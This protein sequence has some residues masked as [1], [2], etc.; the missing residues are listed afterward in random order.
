MIRQA[1]IAPER[2]L[3]RLDAA[4][5]FPRGWTSSAGQ[6]GDLMPRVLSLESVTARVATGDEHWASTF[7]AAGTDAYQVV[8]LVFVQAEAT[9]L[10]A[11][12]DLNGRI[13]RLS[14]LLRT[15]LGNQSIDVQHEVVLVD[16]RD[17]RPQVSDAVL[18]RRV[19]QAQREAMPDWS[20]HY[21]AT[22]LQPQ[23]HVVMESATAWPLA[24][25][26]LLL[27]LRLLG[28]RKNDGPARKA[29]AWRGFA[30]R[31]WPAEEEARLQADLAKEAQEVLESGSAA[32]G[33][34]SSSL[35]DDLARE[36]RRP[37]SALSAHPEV[38]PDHTFAPKELKNQDGQAERREHFRTGP[39][40]A[41]FHA[42][43][44]TPQYAVTVRATRGRSIQQERESRE[45]TWRTGWSLARSAPLGARQAAQVLDAAPLPAGEAG[46]ERTQQFRSLFRGQE[47]L[48]RQESDLAACGADIEAAEV[49]HLGAV[50]RLGVAVAVTALLTYVVWAVFHQVLGQTVLATQMVLTVAVGTGL[51]A[52]VTWLLERRRIDGAIR[53]FYEEGLLGLYDSRS[54]LIAKRG[55]LLQSATDEA[56]GNEDRSMRRELRARMDRLARLVAASLGL[57]QGAFVRP[58]PPGPVD[59]EEI[60]DHFMPALLARPGSKGD[61]DVPSMRRQELLTGDLE[62][63][64][65]DW[66][67]LLEADSEDQI[68]SQQLA[69][70]LRKRADELAHKAFDSI[71]EDSQ[72]DLGEQLKS[73]FRETLPDESFR[74]GLSVRAQGTPEEVE[75]W[76]VL[77][78]QVAG[79]AGKDRDPQAAGLLEH[80][81]LVGF[82]LERAALEEL[83]SGPGEEQ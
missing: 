50:P 34:G 16:E 47:R 69:Q 63:L 55:Q 27:G 73:W 37:T 70:R 56:L 19:I 83:S 53:A 74:E 4:G 59:L 26:N 62:S 5:V 61:G 9:E 23:A 20:V 75:R 32:S 35:K 28:D 25:S 11:L 29:F 51:A 52:F 66:A 57:D 30:I 36:L 45:G 67:G 68:H 33:G 71:V 58:I 31:P 6:D 12:A 81:G 38:P 7:L 39:R 14:G 46:D 48:L 8:W 42:D 22:R 79:V 21:M 24:V 10:R 1:L 65:A 18:R 13:R 40:L 43:D 80:L 64:R 15:A 17:P 76:H 60:R 82:R 78:T 77:P 2:A 41:Q 72:E 54:E 44:P 49:S 3:G